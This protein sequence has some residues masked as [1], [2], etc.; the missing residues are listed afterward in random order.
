MEKANYLIICMGVSGTG[1]TTLAKF[2]AEKLS[3]EFLEADNFHSSENIAHMALGKALS[4]EM[5]EPWLR[6]MCEHLKSLDGSCSLAYSGLKLDHRDLFRKLGRP[7]LFLHLQGDF[8]V[9]RERMSNRVGHFM[10]ISLLQSQFDSLE[11]TIA[12]SDVF[13]I[14][15]NGDMASVFHAATQ[16]IGIFLKAD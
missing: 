12:E 10:P 4:D 15:V 3:I 5:R 11:S 13:P 6:A 7:I 16:A 8:D 9:I 1:K 2:V 14:S